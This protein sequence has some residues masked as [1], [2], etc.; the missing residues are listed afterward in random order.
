MNYCTGSCQHPVAHNE[1]N[2]V[3]AS[4]KAQIAHKS[5]EMEDP[6]CVP[7]S[8]RKQSIM[9]ISSTGNFFTIVNAEASAINCGCR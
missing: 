9:Y 5:D 8:Y 1:K 7:I 6:S 4:L 2:N 3:Y